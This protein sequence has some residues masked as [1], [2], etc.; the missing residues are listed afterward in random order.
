MTLNSRELDETKAECQKLRK[1]L[2]AR[3]DEIR[4]YKR[5][6]EDLNFGEFRESS[7]FF[8]VPYQTWIKVT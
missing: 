1:E 2:E 3:E 8:V 4:Q 5:Q 6:V 7:P